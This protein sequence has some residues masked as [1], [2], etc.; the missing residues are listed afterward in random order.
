M[1]TQAFQ[2]QIP[3]IHCFGCGPDNREGLRIKSQWSGAS[4]SRCLFRPAPHHTA[5]PRHTVNGGIIATVMDCHGIC[6]AIADGYR[7]AGRDIGQG[8]EVVYVTGSLSV[9]YLAPAPIDADLEFKASISSFGEKKTILTC[10]AASRGELV[11]TGEVVAVRVP[12]DWGKQE[13]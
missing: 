3:D 2:D 5:G 13:S 1:T 6:T 11:A 4:E 12:A 8:E 7:R 10:T 9:T